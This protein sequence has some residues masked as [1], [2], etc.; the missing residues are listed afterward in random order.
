MNLTDSMYR[1]VYHGSKKH[2]VDLKDVVERA[3]NMGMQKMIITGGSLKD[4]K[5]AL[6]ISHT[7]GLSL[8]C[9]ALLLSVFYVR[10]IHKSKIIV[11]TVF[12]FS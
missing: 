7:H 3:W 4:S 8:T 6:H 1:G 5:E 11:S 9:S 10:I 12:K 2:E